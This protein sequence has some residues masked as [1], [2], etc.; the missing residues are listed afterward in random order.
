MSLDGVANDGVPG[1]NDSVD[2]EGV[3]GTVF[4]DTLTGGAGPDRLDGDKGNDTIAGLGGQR[5][6]ARRRRQRH[7]RTAATAPTP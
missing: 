3:I 5:H 7:A 2:A 1:E 6:R 4:D